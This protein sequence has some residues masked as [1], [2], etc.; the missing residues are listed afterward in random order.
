MSN[1][2]GF[3]KERFALMGEI[4]STISHQWKQP[5]NT[6]SLAVMATKTSFDKTKNL[7]KNL[8]IIE[9]SISSLSATM[10]GFFDFFN[11]K[12]DSVLKNI[13]TIIGDIQRIIAHHLQNKKIKLIMINNAQEIK[14]ASILSLALISIINDI[15]KSL[16]ELNE[17]EITLT[18]NKNGSFL[19][20]EFNTT[21]DNVNNLDFANEII[22]NIFNG[23]L[24]K[25]IIK[26]KDSF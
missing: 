1:H 12:N 25:N 16:L 7:D 10:D 2:I 8:D 21:L 14:V 11:P 18:F 6:I 23:H 4:L 15:K 13:D 5:L 22:K 20:I 26:L 17:K 9:D 3:E 19:E 24:D